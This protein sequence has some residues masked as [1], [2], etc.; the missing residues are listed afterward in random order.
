MDYD[1]LTTYKASLETALPLAIDR[2]VAQVSISDRNT[3]MLTPP[4]IRR[5]LRIVIQQLLEHDLHNSGVDPVLGLRVR[6]K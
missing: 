5:E 1:T 4:Q 6:R 2:G 3:V